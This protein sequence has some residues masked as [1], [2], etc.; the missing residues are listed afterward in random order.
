MTSSAVPDNR[1]RLSDRPSDGASPNQATGAEGSRFQTLNG[2]HRG[3]REALP[4]MALEGLTGP[5]VAGSSAGSPAGARRRAGDRSSIPP[6]GPGRSALDRARSEIRSALAGIC[7]DLGFETASLFVPEQRGWRLLERQGP[8]R[9]WHNVL[10]PGAFEGTAEAAQYPDVQSIPGVGSR[11]AALGCASVAI[12]PLPDGGRVLLDSG[13]PCRAD[14]WIDRARPYL[15]LISRMAGSAWPVAGAAH[16]HEEGGALARLLEACRY[17]L[18]RPEVTVEQFLGAARVALGADEIFFIAEKGGK[19]EVYCS[20]DA[21]RGPFTVEPRTRILR[22]AEPGLPQATL[23]TL[24]GAVGATSPALAGAIGRDE[25]ESEVVVAGWAEGPA[26]SPVSMTV[27][28][29]SVSMA[30]A[31]VRTRREAVATLVSRERARMAYAL[32]DGLTQSVTGTLLELEG[33]AGRIERDPAEAIAMVEGCKTEIRQSLAELRE[34]LFDLSTDS[35]SS[36]ADESLSSYVDDVVKRWRLPARVAVEGDLSTVPAK[37]LSVAYVV[38]REALTN[39]AKHSAA[40]SVTVRLWAR[41]DDLTVIVGDS[42][43]GFTRRHEQAAREAKHVGLD[44]L[45]RRVAEIGGKLQVE[46]GPGKGTRVIA[47][48]PIGRAAS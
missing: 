12:L 43:R 9:R 10:D 1:R 5:D 24:A 25:E 46:S 36:G 47:E 33:L 23:R 16:S 39:A 14:G 17:A 34:I 48:L 11:L 19:T 38:I 4:Q 41:E 40:S 22:R 6:Q 30:M 18:A 32:H 42:G 3:E 28:A 7:D 29:R 15:E 20:P 2:G 8:A 35:E 21:G 26:L 45:K 31:A 37:V 44:M 13:K 27:A